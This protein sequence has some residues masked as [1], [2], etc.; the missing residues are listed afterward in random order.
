MRGMAPAHAVCSF[1]YQRCSWL[2]CWFILGKLPC[3]KVKALSS[4]SISS[5]PGCEEEHR[6]KEKTK[7]L[8]AWKNRASQLGIRRQRS[9][10]IAL[11][12]L[13]SCY[14][15]NCCTRFLTP[16]DLFSPTS[17]KWLFVHLFILTLGTSHSLISV[18]E[19]ECALFWS[20]RCG[21]CLLFYCSWSHKTAWLVLM[22]RPLL[23]KHQLPIL[24]TCVGVA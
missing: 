19:R 12:S 2:G 24:L 9:C 8:S 15:G 13:Q 5:A 18:L 1:P 7:A 14:P 17:F 6:V 22:G 23:P 16:L 10:L 3:P 11:Q 4:D 21:K 20:G